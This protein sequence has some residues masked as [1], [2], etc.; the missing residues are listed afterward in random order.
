MGGIP[1]GIFGTLSK[2]DTHNEN[3]VKT[4]FSAL[5]II[6]FSFKIGWKVFFSRFERIFGA[7]FFPFIF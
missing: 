6:W 5:K 3:G 1:L 2:G 7:R 4:S